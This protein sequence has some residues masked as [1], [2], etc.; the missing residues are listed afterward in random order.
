MKLICGLGNPGDEYKNTRHNAGFIFIEKF[1]GELN[2][3]EFKRKNDFNALLAES[4]EG[5]EK[6][7]LVKPLTFM[8]KS[9]ESISKIA[10]FYKIPPE[11]IFIVYDDIDLPLG[12]IRYRKAGSAGTHNGMRSIISCLGS[13]DYPR[14]R[15]GIESR[16]N[17]NFPLD[18]FVLSRFTDEEMKI[19]M[20]SVTEGLAV[21]K[22]SL[23]I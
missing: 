11:E 14:L 1:A 6:I 21:L 15:L 17:K 18:A 23:A 20:D 16:T 4:G 9:G 3:G 2:A 22:N 19:F 7:I 8:N 10:N 5:S 12:S 13:Q